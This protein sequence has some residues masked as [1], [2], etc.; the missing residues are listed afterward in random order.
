M[1]HALFP[2]VVKRLYENAC[3]VCRADTRTDNRKMLVDAAHI[4]PF[5]THHNDDPRNGIALCKNHHW[6]FDQGAFG[7]G[8]DYQIIL[9]KRVVET[10]PLVIAV[11][12]ISVPGQSELAPAVE[13]LRWHRQNVLMQ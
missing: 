5:A 13:A 7:I 1:R 9:S 11:T 12:R 6:G 3:A 10:V 8:D 2:T 4:L